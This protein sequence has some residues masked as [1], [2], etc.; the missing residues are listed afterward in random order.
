[1]TDMTDA[2]IDKFN[3][4]NF[5]KLISQFAGPKAQREQKCVLSHLPRF[6]KTVINYIC[7]YQHD[8]FFIASLWQV[9][10]NLYII[11]PYTYIVHEK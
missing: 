11:H 9:M 4:T 3:F 1:M 6:R 7:P 8:N 2:L 5:Y 10:N